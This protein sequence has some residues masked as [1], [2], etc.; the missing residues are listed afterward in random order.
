MFH[1][2]RHDFEGTKVPDDVQ[3][4]TWDVQAK[5]CL[6]CMQHAPLI[7][8]FTW[9]RRS[10]SWSAMQASVAAS[11]IA[12]ICMLSLGCELSN[13]WPDK[14]AIPRLHPEAAKLLGDL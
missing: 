1:D 6:W 13:S 7:H 12:N 8:K 4:R 3:R 2:F 14:T 11:A 9:I 10:H 5:A